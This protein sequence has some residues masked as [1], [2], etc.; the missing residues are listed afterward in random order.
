MITRSS[1]PEFHLAEALASGPVY[2]D[3]RLGGL[4]SVGRAD[5]VGESATGRNR[6]SPERC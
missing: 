1:A 3:D 4:P 6:P 5:E 2:F